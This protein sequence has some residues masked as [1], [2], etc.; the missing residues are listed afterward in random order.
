GQPSGSASL[1]WLVPLF[2][3][4]CNLDSRA[5]L[6]LGCLALYAVGEL[7]GPRLGTL[8]VL[9]AASRRHLLQVTGACLLALLVH[10]WHV[11]SL[12][13]VN[14]VYGSEYP[15]VREF[16]SQVYVNPDNPRQV[17]LPQSTYFPVWYG[18][19]FENFDL[20][21][22]SAR[23]RGAG[24]LVI[25]AA[26]SLVA[27]NFRRVVWGEVLA[28][29]GMLVAAALAMREF[30][31]A[32]LV[33]G[34][35]AALMGQRWYAANCRQEYG[36]GKL[37]LAWSRGGRAVT[38]VALAALAF[39]G[40]TGRLR[41]PSAAQPGFGLDNNLASMVGDLQARLVGL[42]TPEATAAPTEATDGEPGATGSAA[43]QAT[44]AA[45][46]AGVPATPEVRRSFDDRP[47][48]FALEHGDVL[49][50]LGQKPF[51]DTRFALYHHRD[52]EQNLLA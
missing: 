7:L 22:A 20:R 14:L 50:W 2:V 37:E 16:A 47:F 29:L 15:A 8:E 10:P 4:W 38:V 36:T 39:F 33:A 42:P 41:E 35:V 11:H 40:G 45:P 32:A 48:N 18:A 6:G 9:P 13:S 31:A 27:L 1:W 43:A 5:Y 26:I 25:L 44:A 3:V 51:A 28:L 24:L 52:L 34:I 19:L 23:A 30:P 17:Y 49:I 21:E 12:T 46:P